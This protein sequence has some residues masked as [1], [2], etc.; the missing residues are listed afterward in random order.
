MAKWK[1]YTMEGYSSQHWPDG[2]ANGG[3]CFWQV[4]HKKRKGVVLRRAL[5]SNGAHS[6]AGEPEVVAEPEAARIIE[7]AKQ[8]KTSP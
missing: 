2:R 4:K 1:T 7:A 3:V 5:G 6:S 8:Y